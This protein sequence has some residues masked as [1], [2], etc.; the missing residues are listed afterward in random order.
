MFES[1]EEDEGTIA[2]ENINVVSQNI[3]L[4]FKSLSDFFSAVNEN[5]KEYGNEKNTDNNKGVIDN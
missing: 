2:D 5:E 3:A 4:Y 1:D